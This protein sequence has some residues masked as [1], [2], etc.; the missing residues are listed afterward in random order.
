MRHA[1]AVT[2]AQ[3]QRDDEIRKHPADDFLPAVAKRLHSGGVELNNLPFVIHR[4]DA[5]EG[6]LQ[7]GR[8]AGFAL[9]QFFFALPLL[10]HVP[11][12]QHHADHLARRITDGSGSI[13]NGALC[14]IPGD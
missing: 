1:L 7:N 2:L 14:S 13:I 9:S 4:D 11:E 12:D 3:R 6:R 5:I 10:G 8:F